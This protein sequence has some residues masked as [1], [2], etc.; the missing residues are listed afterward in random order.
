MCFCIEY[1][2]YEKLSS[3]GYTEVS[4]LEKAAET[5]LQFKL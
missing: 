3:L 2:H 1:A 4:G 5:Y